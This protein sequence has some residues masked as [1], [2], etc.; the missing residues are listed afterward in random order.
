MVFGRV[1]SGLGSVRPPA[2]HGSGAGRDRPARRVHMQ[3]LICAQRAACR[4]A[5]S[6]TARHSA[7]ARPTGGFQ[8]EFRRW[9]THGG[10]PRVHPQFVVSSGIRTAN[11]PIRVELT[12]RGPGGGQMWEIY[13]HPGVPVFARGFCAYTRGFQVINL[14]VGR[15]RDLKF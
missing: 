9:G 6:A 4:L 8:D 2:G 7:T 3:H 14:F 5:G 13:F 12:P 11:S 1:P 10:Y 15:E